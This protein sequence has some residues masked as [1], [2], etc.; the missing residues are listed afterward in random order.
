MRIANFRGSPQTT[1]LNE[2]MDQ[3]ADSVSSISD[4]VGEASDAIGQS[5]DNAQ[6][7]VDEISGISSSMDITNEVTEKLNDST[8]QFVNI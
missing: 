1:S 2:I 4:S 6:D 3:M 7:I 5:A 8:K